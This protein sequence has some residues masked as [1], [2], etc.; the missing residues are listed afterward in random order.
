M[1]EESHDSGH[2]GPN[3]DD[4]DVAHSRQSV[5]NAKLVVTFSAAIAA[6]FVATTLQVGDP[7]SWEKWAAA[8]MGLTLVLTLCVVVLPPKHSTKWTNRAYCLMVAQVFLS[9][10]ASV[11]ATI[12]LVCRDW[13]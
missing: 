10:G 7:N 2:G 5:H 12:G 9:T 13:V 3:P 1:N 8:L 11:A 4:G 6:T